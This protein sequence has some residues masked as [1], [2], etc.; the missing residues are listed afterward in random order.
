M[1]EELL[2]QS[3]TQWIALVTGVIYVVLAARTNNACWLF[4]IV[5]CAFIAWDDFFTFRLYADGVLQITYIGLGVLGLVT[6]L[7]NGSEE[8]GSFEIVEDDIARHAVVI[9]VAAAISWPLSLLLAKYTDA[10]FGFL[11]TLTT[12]LSLYA[13]TLLVRKVMSNWLYWIII[14]IVY[15]YIFA[16]SGGTLVAVLYGIFTVVAI[17]GWFNWRSIRLKSIEMKSK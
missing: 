5:S 17:Y 2:S 4:G 13:T 3:W 14:D 9:A 12:L 16:R 8:G 11:D 10:Q 6:W 7:R 15:V 1:I